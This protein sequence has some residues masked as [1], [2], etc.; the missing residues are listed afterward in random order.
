VGAGQEGLTSESVLAKNQELVNLREKLKAGTLEGEE[1]VAAE[2][3]VDG[4]AAEVQRMAAEIETTHG[5]AA[6]ESLIEKMQGQA[7]SFLPAS[8]S[9]MREL[10]RGMNGTLP[11]SPE[12]RV[13]Q[14]TRVA[15]KVIKGFRAAPPANREQAKAAQ[16]IKEKLG[17]TVVYY[18]GEGRGV[19]LPGHEGVLF[20]NRG[21]VAADLQEAVG[22]EFWH[23]VQTKYPDVAA[24]MR[25]Q[26]TPEDLT[27]AKTDYAERLK[28]QGRAPLADAA[29]TREAEALMMGDAAR[30]GR[31]FR[32]MMGQDATLWQKVQ[33]VF[34]GIKDRLTG[35]SKLVNAALD[36]FLAA[37]G[38]TET[39]GQQEAANPEFL[40]G[41]KFIDEDVKPALESAAETVKSAWEG[42]K[43]LIAPQT[44][45][46]QG[47]AGEGHPP[48][49]GGRARPAVRPPG[50]SVPRLA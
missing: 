30:R 8:M 17:Q 36:S 40:P 38:A 46:P 15:E 11:A 49:A 34:S 5:E 13:N 22:H 48:R 42:V 19:R 24:A 14:A 26:F 20:I 27:A 16:E 9:S 33:D 21:N 3:Q 47:R 35:K 31:V 50:R 29:L 10:T 25:K 12:E 6:S 43:S 44:R 18:D 45:S 23:E 2:K 37:R 7:P 28:K 1:K 4:L 32:A 39:K 41:Q